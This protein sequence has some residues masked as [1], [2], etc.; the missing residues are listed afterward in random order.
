[1]DDE[2][3]IQLEYL[4]ISPNRQK[5]LK[6]FKGEILRPYQISDMTG[7]NKSTVSKTLGQ[8]KDK[9]FVY[10]LNPTYSLPRLYKLTPKGEKYVKIID[11]SIKIP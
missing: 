5:V 3:L 7:L 6:A 2:T 10:L 1:M 8:L 9:D 11:Y 4:K